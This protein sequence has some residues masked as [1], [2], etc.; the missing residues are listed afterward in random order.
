M[1]PNTIRLSAEIEHAA[2]GDLRSHDD[3]I[4]EGTFRFRTRSGVMI[5]MRAFRA[6]LVFALVGCLVSPGGMALQVCFCE[7]FTPSQDRDGNSSSSDDPHECCEHAHGK[8]RLAHRSDA[9]RPLVLDPDSPCSCASLRVPAQPP[10]DTPPSS[11]ELPAF[12][13]ACDVTTSRVHLP[14]GTPLARTIGVRLHGPPAARA[15]L[16]LRI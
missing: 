11:Q 5:S 6:L 10:S 7:L 3:R 1:G 14:R 4:C 15:N 12:V 8:R 16:P 9:S 2:A 13:G